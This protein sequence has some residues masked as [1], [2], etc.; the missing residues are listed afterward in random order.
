ML[1]TDLWFLCF[2]KSSLNI[3]KFSV[4]VL[5]KSSL[6][7]FEHYFA[8]VWNEHNCAVVWT[9]FD[10]AFL[11]DW[12]KNWPFPVLWS[13]LSLP[14]LDLPDLV[15]WIYSSLPLDNHKGFSLGHAWMASGFLYF[16]QFKP[17]FGNKEFMIWVT[18]SSRSC[19][20]WLHRFS[21]SLAARNIIS[22]ISV[23]TIWWCP[24]VESSLVLLEEGVWYDQCI[25]LAKLCYPL[26]F[27]ILYSK[28]KFAFYS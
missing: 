2:S 21:P 27:F 4:H 24:C 15:P 16:L 14:N 20:C 13:L 23:L 9:F 11:W 28:A 18:V 8:S 3:W 6:E 10:V 19:F 7:N 25:L 22:L 1:A 5:L 12:N 26:P 17:E